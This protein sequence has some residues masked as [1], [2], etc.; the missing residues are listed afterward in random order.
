MNWMRA[1]HKLRIEQGFYPER[2]EWWTVMID[3]RP[4]H[5][6]L[7]RDQAVQFMSCFLRGDG[8]EIAEVWASSGAG[9]RAE[10]Q[11]YAAEN[12]LTP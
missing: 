7:Y 4:H 6:F 12:G 11:K 8:R 5:H 1:E 2:A 3:D 9:P 10:W